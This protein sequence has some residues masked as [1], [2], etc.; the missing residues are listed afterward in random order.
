MTSRTETQSNVPIEQAAQYC[1]FH[2]P[3]RRKR[4]NNCPPGSGH[5]SCIYTASPAVRLLLNYPAENRGHSP[6]CCSKPIQAHSVEKKLKRH[7]AGVESS[8]FQ[9]AKRK[10]PP[11]K[12]ASRKIQA[13]YGEQLAVAQ[14]IMAYPTPARTPRSLLAGRAEGPSARKAK[15]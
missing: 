6:V 14:A 12:Q 11:D 10:Q 3:T 15:H 9:Q 13:Q 1:V 2:L 4:S 8:P 5:Q 7:T